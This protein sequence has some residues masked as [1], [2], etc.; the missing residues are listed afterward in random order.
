ML[1]VWL[2]Q[3]IFKKLQALRS[4]QGTSVKKEVN[5]IVDETIE[6]SEGALAKEDFDDRVIEALCR[7]V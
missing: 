1:L 5:K 3:M 6:K 4:F 7:H 2:L